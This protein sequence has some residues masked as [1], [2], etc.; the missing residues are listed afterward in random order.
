LDASGERQPPALRG[1]WRDEM[2]LGL[3]VVNRI[4]G[5]DLDRAA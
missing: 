4:C 3:A 1:G 2:S 5:A